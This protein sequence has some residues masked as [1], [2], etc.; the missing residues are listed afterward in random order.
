MR[1]WKHSMAVGVV[2]TECKCRAFSEERD[3]RCAYDN[4]C[5]SMAGVTIQIH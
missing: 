4:I 3:R 5:I 2:C 1:R